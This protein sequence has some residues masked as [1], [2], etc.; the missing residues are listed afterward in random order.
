MSTEPWQQI[1]LFDVLA[2]HQNSNRKFRDSSHWIL[3]K[4]VYLVTLSKG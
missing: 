2:R 1:D 4:A 3:A